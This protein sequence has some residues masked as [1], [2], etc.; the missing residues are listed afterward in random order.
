MTEPEVT[1]H[2]EVGMIDRVVQFRRWE[3]EHDLVVVTRSQSKYSELPEDLMAALEEYLGDA[4]AKV[5]VGGELGHS[6]EYG[7]KAQAFVSISVHCNSDEQT[8]KE[9]KDLLQEKVRAYVDEDLAEMIKDR[10]RY[11]QQD[12]SGEDPGRVARQNPPK[13]NP[14]TTPRAARPRSFRR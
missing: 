6:K 1:E 7:C 14:K 2:L 10:D 8:I 9:V 5:T 3:L 4:L 11:M 13:A 12:R